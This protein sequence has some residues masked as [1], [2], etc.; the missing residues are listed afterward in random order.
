[1]KILVFTIF[2]SLNF[3]FSPNAH[4]M[5]PGKM[6]IMGFHGTTPSDPN[7]I[8][9][10]KKIKEQQLGGVILFNRNIK[11]KAQLK[12]LISYLKKDTSIF[13]AIDH[14]GGRVNR[15]THP[16]FNLQTLSPEAFCKKPIDHQHHLANHMSRQLKEIGINLNLGGVVDL[17]PLIG[18]SSI[19]NDNRCFSDNQQTASYC[20]KRLISAHAN[21]H[22]FYALK[23]FPGHGSTIVDSHYSLPDITQS[24]SEYEHMPYHQLIHQSFDYGMVMMGHLM[25]RRVDARYPASLSRAH[26]ATLTKTLTYNGLIITDD[27][28]MRALQSFS[29]NKADLAAAAADAGNHLLLFEHLSFGQLNDV[30]QRLKNNAKHQPELKKHIETATRRINAAL[31]HQS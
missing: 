30:I 28:N 6:I 18:P 8:E 13:V 27:L 16:S 15:L 25:N 26:I 3:S 7:V 5:Y 21:A 22:I 2:F 12:R 17:A 11:N 20:T 1:M 31:G 4:A 10:K 9:L 19:C 24:H 23:H 14:E 29:T